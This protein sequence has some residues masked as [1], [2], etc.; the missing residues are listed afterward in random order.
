MGARKLYAELVRH[1]LAGRMTNHEYEDTC[2]SIL[3]QGDE[4][5]GQVYDKLWNEY[6]DFREHR[7][8]RKHGMPREGRRV[9][10][11]W[12]MFLRSGRPY[13][14]RHIK[15]PNGLIALLT[16]GIVR[17]YENPSNDGSDRDC[18]PYYHQSDFEYDLLH[19][20]LLAGRH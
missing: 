5:V 7:M 15:Y 1:F 6:C 2:D 4:A 16:L 20:W 17:R 8:G 13:E 3:N 19:P 14:Y 18:W 11:R 12:I 9:A 10:A